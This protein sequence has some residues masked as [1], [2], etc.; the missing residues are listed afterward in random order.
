MKVV[1]VILLLASSY[2]TFTYALSLWK[3]D[4]N[5]LGGVGAALLALLS[6]FGPVMMMFFY[7]Y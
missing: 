5:K 2:Y 4:R 1:L 3:D 6:F 7:K